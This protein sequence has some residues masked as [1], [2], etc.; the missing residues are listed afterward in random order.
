MNVTADN[1]IEVRLRELAQLF[2]LMDPSPFIDRDL[3]A[4][5]EEFIV[6]WARELPHQGELELVVHLATAPLPDRAAGTEEAVRHYFASRVEVKR[7]EL[8]QLLRRGRA[9]LLIG[10]LFLGACF[11]LGEVALHLLPAGRNSFV[12]LGLQIVGWVAM[13]RPLEIYL[14]DWWP[15]RADLRLLE[16]LARMRVRLNLPASG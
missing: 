4:D 11:G 3:D 13:W 2:N 15:I 7:R 5:A 6:G 8:R 10:V 14:Y 12:E 9:S 16:R 1:R